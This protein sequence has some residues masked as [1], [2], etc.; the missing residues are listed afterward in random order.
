MECRRRF[1]GFMG[2]IGFSGSA[3]EVWG[4]LLLWCCFINIVLDRSL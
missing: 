4:W 2:I 3:G 1:R